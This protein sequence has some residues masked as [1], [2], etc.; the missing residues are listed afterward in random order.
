MAVDVQVHGSL[1]ND[2]AAY[3]RGQLCATSARLVFVE[4]RK[5]RAGLKGLRKGE[6]QETG[7]LFVRFSMGDNPVWSAV[8]QNSEQSVLNPTYTNV[9]LIH[10]RAKS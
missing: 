10:K 5:E 1:D 6:L 8:K 9:N 2:A 3:G 4:D 7:W